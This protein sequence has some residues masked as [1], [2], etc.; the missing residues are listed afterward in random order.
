MIW[1]REG[2]ETYSALPGPRPPDDGDPFSGVKLEIDILQDIRPFRV[3][4]DG[5]VSQ[6]NRACPR[7]VLWD[8]LL[9]IVGV[10]AILRAD[11]IVRFFL[12]LQ[13]GILAHAVELEDR[14]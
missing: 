6:L 14:R 7:P 3:V 11:S 8:H 1:G 5:D 2:D 12:R 10:A 9:L 13:L 4:A